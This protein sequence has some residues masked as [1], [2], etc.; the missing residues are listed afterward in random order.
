MQMGK[1]S[2]V[3]VFFCIMSIMLWFCADDERIA[4]A[5]QRDIILLPEDSNLSC[6]HYN[7]SNNFL[8]LILVTLDFMK[9]MLNTSFF[10]LIGVTV[11]LYV[12]E[13]TVEETAKSLEEANLKLR[14]ALRTKTEFLARC[15][16][17][18]RT[19]LNGIVGSVDILSST[20]LQPE[21]ETFLKI[22][23]EC[24]TSLTSLIDGSKIYTSLIYFR[25]AGFVKDGNRSTESN[26][27]F[28]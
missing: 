13:M 24:S 20:Y 3:P 5:L 18:L 17:E 6:P 14:N 22:V 11:V 8:R 4:T 28:C 16:H 25:S 2:A 1:K 26:L 27:R 10:Q 19:P 12:S 23:S 7:K 9:H 15:S 21:Q